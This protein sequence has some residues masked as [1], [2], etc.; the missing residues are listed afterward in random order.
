MVYCE[1][2]NLSNLIESNGIKKTVIANKLGMSYTSL[3]N[4]LAG[5]TEFSVNEALALADILNIKDGDY[6]FYF[7]QKVANVDNVAVS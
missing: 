6:A 2:E 3:L 4:K 7:T 1:L 5:K